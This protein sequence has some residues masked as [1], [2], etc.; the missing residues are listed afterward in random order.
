MNIEN[1][2]VTDKIKKIMQVKVLDMWLLW[3]MRPLG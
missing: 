1:N 3:W 2:Q